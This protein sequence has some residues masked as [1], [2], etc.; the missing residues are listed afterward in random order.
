MQ[1]RVD[2]FHTVGYN[3]DLHF[4]I[5][6]GAEFPVFIDYSPFIL[7]YQGLSFTYQYTESLKDSPPPGLH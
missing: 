3:H 6:E 4:T 7:V 1:S 2:A 5:T